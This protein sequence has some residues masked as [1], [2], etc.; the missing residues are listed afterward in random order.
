MRYKVLKITA[1]FSFLIFIGNVNVAFA[2][3][4]LNCLFSKE[5]ILHDECI[6]VRVT[7]NKLSRN[8]KPLPKKEREELFAK[9]IQDLEKIKDYSS[10]TSYLV[11]VSQSAYYLKQYDLAESR[12][13]ASLGY[14]H[15][16]ENPDATHMAWAILT[17][18]YAVQKNINLSRDALRKAQKGLL[19]ESKPGVC[20]YVLK[21]KGTLEIASQNYEIANSDLDRAASM[22]QERAEY[23]KAG[24]IY[25]TAA[26][27]L[28]T[29]SAENAI[30][31]Y[32]KAKDMYCLTGQVGVCKIYSE[33]TASKIQKL[34]N[35]RG[36]NNDK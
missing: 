21:E 13:L 3:E 4:N 29:R 23:Y 22:F 25:Y 30:L 34:V 16:S 19:C 24:L 35:N 8:S 14:S 27:F 17:G 18:V 12:A 5:A 11:L 10:I 36:H 33:M 15:K 31:N 2:E 20:A 28:A 7:F 9:L 26:E 32:N 6:D 1:T